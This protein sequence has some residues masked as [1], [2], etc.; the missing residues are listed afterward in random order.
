MAAPDSRPSAFRASDADREAVIRILRDGSVDGRLSNDTFLRRVDRALRARRI[1]EL[2]GLLRDLPPEEAKGSGAP[3]TWSRL[4]ARVRSARPLPARLGAALRAP[5]LP[6]LVLP[7]G[8]R[9]VFTI[10]RSPDSDLPLGDIT[11]SWH[12]AELRRSGDAWVLTDLGST[13]GTRVNGW[14]AES[15]FAVR[16]GDRVS[17]GRAAFL[18]ADAP[19][20][21]D[22]FLQNGI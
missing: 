3:G 6:R 21:L 9:T 2:A 16:P 11:V 7:R 15:G 8:P 17:F 13:N 18:L 20:R 4:V 14:R 1:D 5:R 10:G 12:H 22:F 19:G